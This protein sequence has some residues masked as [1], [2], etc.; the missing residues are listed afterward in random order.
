MLTAVV[1]DCQQ[2]SHIDNSSM[3]IAIVFGCQYLFGSIYRHYDLMHRLISKL[4]PRLTI[5]LKGTNCISKGQFLLLKY[6][7][8]WRLNADCISAC[9]KPALSIELI[10]YDHCDMKVKGRIVVPVRSHS[11][12]M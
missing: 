10:N 6:Y 1:P 9:T 7:R 4:I 11:Q 5:L 3:L 12:L 8:I 2:L